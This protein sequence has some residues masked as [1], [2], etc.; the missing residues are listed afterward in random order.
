M[1]TEK[2]IGTVLVYF[3]CN[4]TSRKKSN[5]KIITKTEIIG[6]NT[7]PIRSLKNKKKEINIGITWNDNHSKKLSFEI[8]SDD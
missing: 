5:K 3:T 1:K 7:T 8:D 2:F 4:V 6:V